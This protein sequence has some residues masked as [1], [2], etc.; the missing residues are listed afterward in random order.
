MFKTARGQEV[1]KE[2]IIRRIAGFI[3][4]DPSA[5]YE[6]TVGTDSQN[7]GMTKMVE[8][9]AVHR[10]GRGG[11]FFYNVDYLRRITN[12]RQKIN[13]ET[14]RSLSVADGI[15]EGI[16]LLL[17]EKDLLLEEIDLSFQIHCDIGSCGKTSM[18]IQEITKWVQSYGYL[19]C[20]KPYSYAASGIANK[21]SK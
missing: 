20:I 3:A 16:E 21:Y 19:C 4:E 8:V 12:L 18:L 11:T 9:I 1:T 7:H 14:M 10:K 5:H 13:E 2:Q 17:L 15:L 6:I